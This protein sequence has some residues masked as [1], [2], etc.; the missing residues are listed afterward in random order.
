MLNLTVF[1][2]MWISC[3]QEYANFNNKLRENRM[4]WRDFET[5]PPIYTISQNIPFSLL[6]RW[7]SIAHYGLNFPFRFFRSITFT[8]VFWASFFLSGFWLFLRRW[9]LFNNTS[10]FNTVKVIQ[11]RFFILVSLRYFHL[12]WWFQNWLCSFVTCYG[13]LTSLIHFH[14]NGCG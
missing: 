9:Y 7:Y 6:V 8:P 11:Y 13:L 2:C 12:R 1:D 3:S 10:T 4:T 5:C 14:I